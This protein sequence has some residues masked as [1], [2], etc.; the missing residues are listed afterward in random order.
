[1]KFIRYGKYVGEA[2]DAID[3]EELVKRLGDFFLQ[4][5][6]ESQYYGVNEMDPDRSMEALRDAILRA[7]QEGDLLPEDTMSDE[8]RE[9]LQDPDAM[10]NQE[11]KDL[12]EKLM[13]R[14]GQEG[15]INPQQ[16]PQVTPPNTTSARGQ[17]GDAQERQ[18]E[19]RFE[20]TDKTVDFLG[21]KTLQDLLGSL[22]RSSFGRH[23]T[24]DL[25]T[26]VESGGVSRQYEFGD[27]LNMDISAT[28]FNAVRREGA[29]VPIEMNYS[30]LM[31]H[32]CEYHSSCATV[33]LL[34]CSHSMI[35]YGEDRFTPA[36][37]VAMALSHLIRTQYPGDTLNLV[38][39][40]DS[41]EEVPIGE[42]ARV[43]VGPY[44]T[45]TRE[46]LR[47]AQRIL[48][49]QKKDMRQIVMITDGKPS[50]LTLEDGRIYKNAFGLDPFVVGQTLEEVNKCKRAGIMIN[51]FMLASDYSLVHFVQKITEMCK[52]KAYFTT[53]Y[54]LGQY[55][56]MDYMQR[57]TKNIH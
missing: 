28:L 8:L 53:P 27:T 17:V 47:M 52:G 9:M 18:Q 23:D 42:L 36:K 15:F 20:I 22:G 44:Y 21:F 29:K 13:D 35:L 39:F 41:A 38:L 50:A 49:R 43:Q 5:G 40:H 25:A 34:D 14:L 10:N 11:I 1:M 31:V 3:L 48:L 24:R 56:L 32:Q 4:S 33:V 30:D 16:P 55:L 2:A 19:V 54:N 45:N 51:T 46:G 6:F 37:R 12:I 57:K 26:G 7:L